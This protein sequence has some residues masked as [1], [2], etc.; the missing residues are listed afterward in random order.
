[1]RFSK[2]NPSFEFNWFNRIE[3]SGI[4]E[5]INKHVQNICILAPPRSYKT[6]IASIML[7]KFLS[8]K[9]PERKILVLTYGQSRAEDLKRNF[10][11]A[12]SNTER[13]V[14]SSVGCCLSSQFDF[15]IMD[16]LIKS[17]LDAENLEF[18]NKLW[19]WY[20]SDVL[21][22]LTHNGKQLIMATQWT[23]NDLHNKILKTQDNWML[24][25]LPKSTI[26]F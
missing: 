5:W 6:T 25:K 4:E 24:I 22:R 19:N 13:V 3:I 16:D 8:D 26:S 7:P 21:T 2:I 18:Q 10:I 23:E 14:F 1:M 15:I 17:K 9:Y 11:R 12:N 20:Y